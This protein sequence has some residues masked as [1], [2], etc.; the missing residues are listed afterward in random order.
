MLTRQASSLLT[1]HL[2]QR[3][4]HNA[5]A[6]MYNGL[7]RDLVTG[8]ANRFGATAS[9]KRSSTLRKASSGSGRNSPAPPQPR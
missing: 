2:S 7:I 6:E 4:A 3:E 1:H 9:V 8:A 5:D